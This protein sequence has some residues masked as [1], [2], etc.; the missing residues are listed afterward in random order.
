[1]SFPL[2]ALVRQGGSLIL[3]DGV[4][5]ILKADLFGLATVAVKQLPMARLDD[6]AV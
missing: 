6:I 3:L 2:H 5:R 4:R 1:L